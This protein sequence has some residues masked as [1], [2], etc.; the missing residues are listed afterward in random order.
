MSQVQFRNSLE[1]VAKKKTGGS[2]GFRKK[3]GEMLCFMSFMLKLINLRQ[4]GRAS[5]PAFSN[6]SITNIINA[7]STIT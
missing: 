7:I 4:K 1:N 2:G 6:N 5:S 3:K